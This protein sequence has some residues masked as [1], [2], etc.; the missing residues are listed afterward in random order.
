MPSGVKHLE[1]IRAA[2][3]E[4]PAVNQLEV[5]RLDICARTRG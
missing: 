1:E 5:R 4:A 2:G 3:L